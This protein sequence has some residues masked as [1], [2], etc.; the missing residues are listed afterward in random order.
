MSFIMAPVIPDEGDVAKSV[1]ALKQPLTTSSVMAPVIPQ[2]EGDV[3][4]SVHSHAYGS[5]P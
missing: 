1:E 5:P 3:A 4:N 2:D